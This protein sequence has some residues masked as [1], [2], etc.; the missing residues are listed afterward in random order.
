MGC[1]M[2]GALETYLNYDLKELDSTTVL[3]TEPN[4]ERNRVLRL[5]RLTR[6]RVI[7]ENNGWRVEATENRNEYAKPFTLRTTGHEIGS[8]T[9]FNVWLASPNWRPLDLGGRPTTR[10]VFTPTT[11]DEDIRFKEVEGRRTREF[12]ARCRRTN[13]PRNS[14]RPGV[15]VVDPAHRHRRCRELL[16]RQA[17]RK[18]PRDSREVARSPSMRF[19]PTC[20]VPKGDATGRRDFISIGILF[21]GG[22]SRPSSV[23]DSPSWG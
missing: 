15:E 6:F 10:T 21:R 7:S 4:N 17:L 18:V 1:T 9:F 20:D 13:A 23:A 8:C 16:R 3:F 22:P 11:A 2:E 14:S 12:S 19:A 5:G